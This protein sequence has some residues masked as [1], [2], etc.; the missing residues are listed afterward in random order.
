M[1]IIKEIDSAGSGKVLL[2]IFGSTSFVFGFPT[3]IATF[4]GA[5]M[6]KRLGVFSLLLG[7]LAT[8]SLPIFYGGSGYLIGLIASRFYNFFADQKKVSE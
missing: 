5:P 7:R 1:V 6:P 2:I 3:T 4:M 8:F